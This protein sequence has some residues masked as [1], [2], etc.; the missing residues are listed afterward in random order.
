MKVHIVMEYG[1]E[2]ARVL[3]IWKT[4]HKAKKEKERL[5]D[6][7]IAYKRRVSTWLEIEKHEVKDG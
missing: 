6:K 5:E 7:H 3:S 1:Y 4:E 2:H